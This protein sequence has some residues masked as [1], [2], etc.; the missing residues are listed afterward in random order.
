MEVLFPAFC[1]PP[2]ILPKSLFYLNFFEYLNL[3]D[4][5]YFLIV[6][7]YFLYTVF[8]EIIDSTLHKK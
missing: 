3:L 8:H 6:C 7:W 5:I 4:S 1:A 2:I